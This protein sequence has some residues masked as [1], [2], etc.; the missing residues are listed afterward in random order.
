M[1]AQRVPLRVFAAASCSGTAGNLVLDPLGGTLQGA[2]VK[3]TGGAILHLKAGNYSFNSISMQGNSSI[4]VDSGPVILNITG[5]GQSTPIDLTGGTTTNSS[6][7]PKKLQ[8][9]YG[10]TG[11][12]KV[13]GG[14]ATAMM[15]FAPNSGSSSRGS[16]LYG[17]VLGDH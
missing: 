2:D 7:V 17:A 5:T 9:L 13:A 15:L 14:A 3:L 1:E 11:D 10:G 4:I 12:V 16:D 6:Y 8:I